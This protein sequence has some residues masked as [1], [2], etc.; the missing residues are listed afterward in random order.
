MDGQYILSKQVVV[1][2]LPRGGG[3]RIEGRLT[4]I[5]QPLKSF[6]M[7]SS[8]TPL[9]GSLEFELFLHEL[10]LISGRGRVDT[11]QCRSSNG[12]WEWRVG[13]VETLTEDAVISCR[14]AALLQPARRSQYWNQTPSQRDSAEIRWTRW[15][16][17]YSRAFLLLDLLA[18]INSEMDPQTLL[19]SI[20]EAARQIM[21]AEASSLML[22]DQQTGELLVK[23]PTGPARSEI[24][25]LR[26]PAGRGFA[27][28]VVQNRKPVVVA[29]PTEDPRFH[30]EIAGAGFR[31]RNLICVP[32]V[33]GK[34]E[35]IGVLQA[36]NKLGDGTFEEEEIPLFSALAEQASIALERGRLIQESIRREVL[37]R[38]L[39]LA[40]E[41]QAGFW[42]RAL[43]SIPGIKIA[44]TSRPAAHVGGDYYDVIPLP[45]NRLG[46]VVA[47]VSGKGVSAAL[48]MAAIRSALRTQ[49][50]NQ[51]S[52][53]DAVFRVN[54]GL[55]GDTPASKF[56]TLFFSILDVSKRQLT[57]VN[58]GHNPPLL[59]D[60]NTNDMQRLEAGGPIVGFRPDLPYESAEV[61][62]HPGHCLVLFSDGI[63]E[64]Q[65][66]SEELFGDERLGQIV[67][68][69]ADADAE[70]LMNRILDAVCRF[71]GTAPQADDMTLLIVTLD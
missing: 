64:A 49:L 68:E 20:M 52:V 9:D 17:F 28:W 1:R 31:T 14:L 56:A 45:E 10:P 63:T 6:V 47:D 25:G 50:E 46:L 36:M 37:E 33:S 70:G 59:W 26:I 69:C 38:E 55:V 53:A 54:N 27:G 19:A 57:Y 4:S 39:T 18:E 67:Q 2:V 21:E 29:S 61:Q 58:A 12:V 23:I 11:G 3:K 40:S 62:L 51:H 24:S 41:I 13:N 7:E 48:L 71:S 34:G 15:I 35:V 30:G 5:S 42:P 60:R 43:P 22:L 16:D 32:L 8:A 65:T 44:G 66:E